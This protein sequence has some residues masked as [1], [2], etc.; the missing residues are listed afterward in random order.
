MIEEIRVHMFVSGLVQG[1][2]FRD[3]IQR[4]ALELGLTGWVRNLINGKVEIIAEGEKER[5]EELVE[6]TKEGPTTARVDNLDIE[7]QE[8]EGEFN[9]FGIRH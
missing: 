6:W 5:I 7:W 2:F 3:S 8:Y 4:K 9:S 1:V